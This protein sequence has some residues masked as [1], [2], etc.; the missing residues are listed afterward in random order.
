[1]T[2]PRKRGYK[3]SSNPRRER[4]ERF[5]KLILDAKTTWLGQPECRDAC[6]ALLNAR[7]QRSRVET[8]TTFGSRPCVDS[9]V[10]KLVQPVLVAIPAAVARVREAVKHQW[11]EPPLRQ[12]DWEELKHIRQEFQ[13]LAVS[14]SSNQTSCVSGI[15]ELGRTV[16]QH[17]RRQPD[18]TRR[19][20]TSDGAARTGSK[21]P[22]EAQDILQ[23]WF[24]AH[25]GHPFVHHAVRCSEH[26]RPSVVTELWFAGIQRKAR[27]WS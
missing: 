2:L 21:L 4:E 24:L 26:V 25:V 23:A 13:R 10:L 20:F 16:R 18:E 5:K 1:M 3:I 12:T 14:R 15:K 8:P 17:P 19:V 7:G 22:S 6:M 11:K 9:E 27:S